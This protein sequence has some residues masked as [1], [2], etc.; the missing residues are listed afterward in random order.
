MAEQKQYAPKGHRQFIRWWTHHSRAGGVSWNYLTEAPVAFLAFPLGET[1]SPERSAG[2]C[3]G[4]Q[5]SLEGKALENKGLKCGS[6]KK[7]LLPVNG[8]LYFITQYF[9]ARAFLSS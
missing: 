8:Y 1:G 6:E 2:E 4:G 9:S 7:C 5:E 3:G